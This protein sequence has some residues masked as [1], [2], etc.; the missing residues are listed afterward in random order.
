MAV[1][2]KLFVNSKLTDSLNL[3]NK[4]RMIKD[5]K[6]NRGLK[7]VLTIGLIIFF[8]Q[9]VKAQENQNQHFLQK[10]GALDSLYSKILNESRMIYIQLP[11]SYTP[12]K[13]QKYPVAYILDGEMFLPTVNDVQ[14]YYS[15]WF[16][17]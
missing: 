17:A 11:A 3:E 15:W 7:I 10:V 8:Q 2:E 14:N 1:F 16:Y 4:I 13:N 5:N 12:E 9:F 6:I